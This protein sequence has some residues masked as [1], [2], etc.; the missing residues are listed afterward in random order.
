MRAERQEIPAQPHRY[1]P[2]T[3]VGDVCAELFA[4]LPRS[5]QRHKGELYVRGLLRAQGRK[6]V[7]NI[8]AYVGG[9][10]AEQSLH[11]FVAS[12]TWDWAPV[13]AALAKHVERTMEPK[14]WVVLPMVISKAGTESVGVEPRFV[15][16]L[17]QVV[18]SQQAFGVWAVDDDHGCPVNW[19][20]ALPPKWRENVRSVSPHIPRSELAA[21]PLECVARAARQLQG[22]AGPPR[23]PVVLDL[24]DAEPAAVARR[25]HAAGLPFLCAVRG[26][27]QVQCSDPALPGAEGRPMAAHRLLL[28]ARTL[29]RPVTWTDPVTRVSG[30]S[31]V[32]GVRVTLGA[33]TRPVLLLGEWTDPRGWPQH[34]WISSLGPMSLGAQL[35]LARTTRTVDADFTRVSVPVG[36]TDFS[37]RSYE[38]W[39][40]HTTLASVAHAVRLLTSDVRNGEPMMTRPA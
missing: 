18:N 35:R 14:A 34:H 28:M 23:R 27:A 3:V 40:R 33:G 24:K 9:R 37:G 12:S 15:S 1:V 8:A 26:S 21:G 38:G 19:R 7:R 30:T 32:A 22:W 4:S 13:R 20:L 29:R 6:S 2:D 5:D 10:A 11:H 36:L 31:L 17:G 25:F 39:H 16:G